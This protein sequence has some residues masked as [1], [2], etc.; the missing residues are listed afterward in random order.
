M[1]SALFFSHDARITPSSRLDLIE[2]HF[3]YCLAFFT[4]WYYFFLL[5]MRAIPPSPSK[6]VDDGSGTQLG[7]IT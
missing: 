5:R 4:E 2:I 1:K 7:S 3:G 6:A